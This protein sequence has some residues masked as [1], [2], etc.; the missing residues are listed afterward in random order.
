MTILVTARQIWYSIRTVSSHD[1]QALT[2]KWLD[3]ADLIVP[4]LTS[5]G[6]C[7]SRLLNTALTN[8]KAI[9]YSVAQTP[10][11]VSFQRIR[12]ELVAIFVT[13]FMLA[14]LH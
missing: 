8:I 14:P 2:A 10:Y 6:M 3:Q 12:L 11:T 7:G 5:T 9:S 4:Q 1:L 13:R